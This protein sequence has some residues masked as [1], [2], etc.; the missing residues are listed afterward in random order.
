MRYLQPQ[1]A[2][3]GEYP[4]RKEVCGSMAMLGIDAAL[5]QGNPGRAYRILFRFEQHD[6][7]LVVNRP[8]RPCLVIKSQL[9]SIDLS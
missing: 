1:A 9:R 3:A 4:G 8:D 2:G 5:S 6:R 7:L